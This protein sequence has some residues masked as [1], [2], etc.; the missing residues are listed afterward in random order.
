[1]YQLQAGWGKWAEQHWM[2][3]EL[4]ALFSVGSK[5]TLLIHLAEGT[6]PVLTFLQVFAGTEVSQLHPCCLL[7][8]GG[9]LHPDPTWDSS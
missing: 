5:A 6:D 7:G 2:L 4:L 9:S 1:M 3:W 8:T